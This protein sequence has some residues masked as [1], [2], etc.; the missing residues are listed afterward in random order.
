MEGKR[1]EWRVEGGQKG[2]GRE[3]E[4]KK[5]R[6]R[7]VEGEGEGSGERKKGDGE[8]AM[9]PIMKLATSSPVCVPAHTRTPATGG[10]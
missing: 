9:A 3:D 7:E 5:G 1:E 8:T 6:K 2:R 10:V 4:G